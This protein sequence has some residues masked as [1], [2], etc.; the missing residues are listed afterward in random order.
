[1]TPNDLAR[2]LNRLSRNV[3]RGTRA[4]LGIDLSLEPSLNQTFIT[5]YANGDECFIVIRPENAKAST[6]MYK[7]K[8][9]LNNVQ[10]CVLLR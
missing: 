4:I 6:Q 8:D 10:E 1:M 2:F 5:D 3:V 9:V 7:A